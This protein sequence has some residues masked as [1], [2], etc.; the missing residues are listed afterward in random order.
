MLKHSQ[1]LAQGLERVVREMGRVERIQNLG[2]LG[3]F[4]NFYSHACGQVR[5]DGVRFF[6]DPLSFSC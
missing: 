1:S 6:F 5:E 3:V 2:D 4:S